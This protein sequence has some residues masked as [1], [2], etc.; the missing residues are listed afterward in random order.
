MVA[1]G[2][3]KQNGMELGDVFTQHLLPEVRPR[4][5]YQAELFMPDVD[6]GTQP[7]VA[8]VNRCADTAVAPDNGY[9]LRCTCAQEGD[10]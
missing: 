9:A 10:G 3:G 4:I 2:M 8:V 6:G 5:N 1:V 7:F